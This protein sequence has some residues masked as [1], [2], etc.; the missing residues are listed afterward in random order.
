MTPAQ[1]VLGGVAGSPVKRDIAMKLHMHFGHPSWD[2]L[3]KI[4]R[5]AGIRDRLLEIELVSISQQCLSC[6]QA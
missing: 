2:I 6:L 1:V 5:N 3:V 4:V